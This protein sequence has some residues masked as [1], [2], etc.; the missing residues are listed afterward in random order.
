MKYNTDNFQ[1]VASMIERMHAIINTENKIERPVI[2]IGDS[3]VQQIPE[4]LLGE[5]VL[6]HGISGM[7]SQGLKTLIDTMVVQYNPQHVYIHVGTNDLG[8]TV[9]S[10]PR[11]IALN[12]AEIVHIIQENIDDVKVTL[13][14]TLPCDEE[15]EGFKTLQRTIRSNDLIDV[16]NKELKKYAEIL[17]VEYIDLN[18]H[19]FTDDHHIRKDLLQ[20]DG[21]HINQH[22]YQELFNHFKNIR[23]K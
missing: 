5:H 7:T 22:G 21:L 23:R 13:I 6:N 8:H 3:I 4:N 2:L 17:N 11:Q 20:D 16:I 19:L 10:S 9:M 18:Q 1:F 14:S 12:V 15:K